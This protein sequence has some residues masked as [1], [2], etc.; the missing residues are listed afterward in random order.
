MKK[1]L[2]T[3][4][5]LSILFGGYLSFAEAAT[6]QVSAWGGGGGGASGTLTRGGSGGGGGAYAGLNAFSITSGQGYIITIGNGGGI[7][8]DG[9]S[10]IFSSTSTLVAFFGLK[11]LGGLSSNPGGLGGSVASSTGDVLHTGGNGGSTLSGAPGAGGG[12]AGT[13]TDGSAGTN[14]T[15]DGTGGNG[16][17][18][19]GGNGGKSGCVTASG[20]GVVPGGGGGGGGDAND[21]GNVN[22]AVGASGK[23][24]ITASLGIISSATGGTHTSDATNDYWTFTSS[25]TW[26]PTLPAASSN[27][28]QL[29]IKTGKLSIKSGKITIKN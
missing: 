29:Q 16:G 25:G 23:V 1:T 17:A 24:I 14:N 11:G 20:S 8:Q 12:A 3:T 6:V 10:T 7:A 9:S 4:F 18:T 22:G 19:G 28:K 5:A 13:T 26:T 21:C 15:Y 2:I 27:I